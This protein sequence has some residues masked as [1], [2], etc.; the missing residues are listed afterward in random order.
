MGLLAVAQAQTNARV[1]N[2][3]TDNLVKTYGFDSPMAQ[4]AM[5][6]VMDAVPAENIK[7]VNG[8]PHIIK[9]AKLSK[10]GVDLK[11]V[12]EN[13]KTVKETRKE[14]EENYKRYKEEKEFSGEE[15]D[16]MDEFIIRKKNVEK[17]ADKIKQ[18]SGDPYSFTG[19][20]EA[21]KILQQPVK[22]YDDIFRAIELL[23]NNE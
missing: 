20:E 4:D 1:I 10:N 17:F 19:G 12:K 2:S 16:D 18:L 5:T 21:L 11:P 14:E 13:I 23:E 3:R 9:P 8:V 7:F 22:T 6:E 15:P